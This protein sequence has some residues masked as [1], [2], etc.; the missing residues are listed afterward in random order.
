[1]ED[2][3]VT[4][5][6]SPTSRVNRSKTNNEKGTDMAAEELGLRGDGVERKSIKALD[7][8][9]GDLISAREKRMKFGKA[10]KE[11]GAIVVALWKENKLK[12]YNYDDKTY[13]L[14]HSEKVVVEKPD[15]GDDD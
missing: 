13:V 15:D 1:V 2:Y 12:A 6:V 14:K 8:A 5:P 9:M 7:E 10:E 11:A 3:S 4:F